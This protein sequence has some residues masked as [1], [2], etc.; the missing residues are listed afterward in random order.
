MS[1]FLGLVLTFCACFRR[2]HYRRQGIRSGYIKV[3]GCEHKRKMGAGIEPERLEPNQQ[4]SKTVSARIGGYM[5]AI[6]E[7]AALL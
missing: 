5:A 6:S 3:Y 4:L 2:G 7:V 1:R